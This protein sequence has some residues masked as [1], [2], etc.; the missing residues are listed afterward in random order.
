MNVL[1]VHRSLIHYGISST[2]KSGLKEIYLL[3]IIYLYWMKSI[4]PQ[5]KLKT[6]FARQVV[7]LTGNANR[8]L[9]MPTYNYNEC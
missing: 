8:Q 2:T 1:I 9:K 6:F 5:L 3:Y 7:L 4:L